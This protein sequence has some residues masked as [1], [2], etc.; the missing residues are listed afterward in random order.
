MKSIT[1][2]QAALQTL[3]GVNQLDQ[4]LDVA[5]EKS[6]DSVPQ[7]RDRALA[8]ELSYGVLRWQ[9]QLQALINLLMKRRLK[10]RDLDLTLCV[11]LGMYQILHTRVPPHAAVKESVEL[12]GWRNK[13]W[14]KALV[15]GVLRNFLRQQDELIA[16]VNQNTWARLAHPQWLSEALSKAWPQDCEQILNAGNTHPPLCLRVNRQQIEREQYL[17]ILDQ[18]GYVGQPTQYSP[19]GLS[20]SKALDVTLIPGFTAG[21][22]SVQDEAAQLAAGLLDLQAGQRVLDAC[23]A[24]GGK[25]AH[26][27][28][29]EPNVRSLLAIESDPRRMQR[30]SSGLTR[31]GLAAELRCA[32]IRQSED[33]WDGQLFDRIL[34]DAPCSATGTIRRRPDIRHRRKPGQIKE[35]AQ[36]QWQLLQSLWPTL[37]PGGQ[38]VYATCSIMPEENHQLISAFLADQ[39]DAMVLPITGPWGREVGPGRQIL[40]GDDNMDGF[41]YALLGKRA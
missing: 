13:D 22:V 39:S 32:D 25:T 24:P 20:L 11:Q 18:A 12:V 3:L 5:L 28:E 14:A 40:S 8:Q 15:N 2:R 26:I 33:W 36:L 21:Q 29:T 38:L 37:A 6:L 34:L 9:T 31:L 23:A 19:V 7:A 4:R 35:F 41:F 30:L 17:E 1:A 10:S 27:L 16:S